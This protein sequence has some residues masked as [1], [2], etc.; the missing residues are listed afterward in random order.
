MH[1][2]KTTSNVI[3]LPLTKTQL[4]TTEENTMYTM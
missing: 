3:N 1:N 2:L 4:R